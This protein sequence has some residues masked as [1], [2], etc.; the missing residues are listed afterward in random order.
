MI[1]NNI[2][3]C[4]LGLTF[5]A[6]EEEFGVIKEVELKPGGGEIDVTE[7][8]KAEFVELKA[9][10]RLTRGVEEQTKAFMQ[11]FHDL[12]PQEAINM[13]DERELEVSAL[14]PAEGG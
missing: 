3:E 6:E 9:Q 7:E 5:T 12:L 1:D 13:F 10:W 11:G 4:G 8:N 2:D 14:R